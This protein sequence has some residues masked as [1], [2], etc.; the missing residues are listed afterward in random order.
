[1]NSRESYWNSFTQAEYDAL[2]DRNRVRLVPGVTYR[3]P[4]NPNHVFLYKGFVAE[5]LPNAHGR[6][7]MPDWACER[8]RLLEQRTH[9]PSRLPQ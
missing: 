1:M 6:E 9:T 2:P 8:L 4:G 3:D 5:M 7:A